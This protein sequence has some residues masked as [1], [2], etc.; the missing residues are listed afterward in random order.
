MAL[1]AV[2]Q[3]RVSPQVFVYTTHFVA[4]EMR[5]ESIDDL[6]GYLLGAPNDFYGLFIGDCA[7]KDRVQELNRMMLEVIAVR[8][9]RRNQTGMPIDFGIG[10][11]PECPWR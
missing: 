3:A 7:A 10:S 8:A 11:P 9:A 1:G 6:R 2:G 4:D 5:F